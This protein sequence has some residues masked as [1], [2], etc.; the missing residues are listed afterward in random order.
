MTLTQMTT[1]ANNYTDESATTTL[2]MEFANEAIATINSDLKCDLD[3]ITSAS[4]DYTAIPETYLRLVII[5]YICYSIKMNDGSVTEA[6]IFMRKVEE[7]MQKLEKN[8][9]LAIDVEDRLEGFDDVY[10]IDYSTN[11][12]IFFLYPN[13]TYVPEYSEYVLYYAN[14]AVVYNSTVY[15]AITNTKGNLPT[16]TNYWREQEAS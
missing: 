12:A 13:N 11:L 8:K 2:T 16:D 9:H 5:P 6:A 3:F 10:T 1:A 4:T 15:I 14:Q 7:G